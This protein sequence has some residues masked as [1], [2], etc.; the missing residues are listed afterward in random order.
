MSQIP[1]LNAHRNQPQ[2]WH[3]ILNQNFIQ[4]KGDASFSNDDDDDVK[5]SVVRNLSKDNSVLSLPIILPNDDIDDGVTIKHCQR[6]NGPR[7]LSP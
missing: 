2:C 7:V 4:L 3:T 6:H 5:F 1:K